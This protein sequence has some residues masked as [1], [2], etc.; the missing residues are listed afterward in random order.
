MIV[1]HALPE[2]I[3]N[4]ESGEVLSGRVG[5]GEVSSLIFLWLFFIQLTCT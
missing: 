5:P 1:N 3:P 2:L 4:M